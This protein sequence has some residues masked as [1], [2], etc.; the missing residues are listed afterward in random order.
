MTGPVLDGTPPMAQPQIS[1]SG[2]RVTS[3]LSDQVIITEAGKAVTGV[4]IFYITGEGNEGSVFI[5]NNHYTTKVVRA[6]LHAAATQIDTI[7]SL[8]SGPV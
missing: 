7:G 8:S 4:Q 6:A 5:A 1:H 3:Q 2:W